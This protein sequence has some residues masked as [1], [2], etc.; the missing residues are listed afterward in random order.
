[1]D[2][3]TIYR[4]ALKQPRGSYLVINNFTR[5]VR[6]TSDRTVTQVIVPVELST[7]IRIFDL[8]SA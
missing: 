2:Q 5:D 8:K 1:M 3:A 4:V 6:L 7:S